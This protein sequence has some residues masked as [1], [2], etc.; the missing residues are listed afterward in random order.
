MGKELSASAKKVQDALKSL[1]ISCEVVELPSSTRTLSY[2]RMMRI[3]QK[4]WWK[5]YL[6]AT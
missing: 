1:G 6:T 5:N 3:L 2:G 4:I